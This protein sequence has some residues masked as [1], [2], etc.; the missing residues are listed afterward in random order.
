MALPYEKQE[1]IRENVDKAEKQAVE[2]RQ[3]VNDLRASGIDASQWENRLRD[4]ESN[5]NKW[6]VFYGL[7]SKRK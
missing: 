6:K 2:I 5:V 3:I 1:Q 4:I 7:Q